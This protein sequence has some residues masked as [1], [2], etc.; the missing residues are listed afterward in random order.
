[1]SDPLQDAL[2]T[3]VSNARPNCLAYDNAILADQMFHSGLFYLDSGSVLCAKAASGASLARIAN[4]AA[5]SSLPTRISASANA[6]MANIRELINV[7]LLTGLL[8]H[9][10]DPGVTVQVIP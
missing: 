5:F 6:T 2:R 3:Y 1:M 4:G 9:E 7:G 8:L 10:Q